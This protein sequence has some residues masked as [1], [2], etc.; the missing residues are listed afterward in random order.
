M[1][2]SS[3]VKPYGRIHEIFV[4]FYTTILH[5]SVKQWPCSEKVLYSVAVQAFLRAVYSLCLCGFSLD[6]LVL[7]PWSLKEDSELPLTAL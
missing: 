2:Y 5:L 3:Y 6:T 7:W 1:T 4:I